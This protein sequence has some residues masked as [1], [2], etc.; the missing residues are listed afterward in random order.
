MGLNWED[1]QDIYIYM[2]KMRRQNSAS[3]NKS[4]RYCS[5]R[6]CYHLDRG[7]ILLSKNLTFH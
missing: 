2:R 7:D 6:K 3:G 4:S 5:E 1:I